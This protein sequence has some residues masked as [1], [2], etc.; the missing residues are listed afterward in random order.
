MLTVALVGVAG[1]AGGAVLLRRA[2]AERTRERAALVGAGWIV[3]LATL[4]LSAWTA[5]AVKGGAV[6]I[7][8]IALGTLGIVAQ[9]RVVRTARATRDM[10][11][12]EP[13]E[14]P[15]RAW[16]GVL[17]FLLAGPLGM[18]AAMGIAFC[19]A[20]WAPGDPRTR[21][22]VGGLLMP[23]GWALA[24]TWTLADQRLL[25]AVAVL[26]GTTV[27]GFALAAVRGLA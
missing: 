18:A 13:L 17:K 8:G 15:S 14:G 27:A 21:I 9:G 6:A 20:T 26:V 1:G 23:L 12:P 25:R 11:A 24:M 7:A 2:W 19:Y 5:G 16:R 22:I 10:L 3:L 4:L